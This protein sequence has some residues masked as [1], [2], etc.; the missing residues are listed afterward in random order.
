MERLHW[1]IMRWKIWLDQ[2]SKKLWWK[3]QD[4]SMYDTIN[5]QTILHHHLQLCYLA[6]FYITVNVSES[7]NK[8]SLMV[9]MV[10]NAI[11]IH[12][13]CNLYCVEKSI[14]FTCK[15]HNSIKER[16]LF[17]PSQCNSLLWWQATMQ[18]RIYKQQTKYIWNVKNITTIVLI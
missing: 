8:S 2:Y 1:A 10:A 9:V 12:L 3:I 7:Y 15:T 17:R 13:H 16:I 4:S 6:W 5:I 11:G 18:F 14:R